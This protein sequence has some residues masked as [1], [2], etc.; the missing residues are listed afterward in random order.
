MKKF[1]LTD[2]STLIGIKKAA[3]KRAQI[4]GLNLSWRRAYESLAVAAD[5]LHAMRVRSS[6]DESSD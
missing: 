3:E 2:L 4:Q 1:D 5:R 6:G